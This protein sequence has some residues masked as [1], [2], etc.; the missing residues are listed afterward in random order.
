MKEEPEN[1][2]YKWLASDGTGLF[3]QCWKP[4]A[5]A[6]AVIALVHGL[7]EHSGR[8]AYW[9]GNFCNKNI[10]VLAMDLRGHGHSS[11]KKGHTPSY[12]ML[13][14]DVELLINKAK[15]L[16]P[17]VPVIPYGH[18]MGG[19]LVLNYVLRNTTDESSC[20]ITSPWLKLSFDVP[21]AK[22]LAGKI[23]RGIY[24]SFSQPSGLVADNL[25]RDKN[26]VQN[27]IND[28]LVHQKISI[29]LFSSVYN[30]GLWAIHQA[31]NLN[32]PCLLMHGGQD[33]ITSP[34][35]SEEFNKANPE[36]ITLKIWEG[37]YHELHNEPEK[38]EVFNYIFNWLKPH[39][40]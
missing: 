6:Q 3:A 5:K 8:W 39:I 34:A 33:Q 16:F 26:V 21:R 13:M 27:Y 28:P 38:E 19:N 31:G 14:N 40:S 11:G 2:I 12:G 20:I 30:N 32:I 24:P 17:G 18:S 4:K 35:G 23:V 25:S 1:T 10:A 22:L 36:K 9:A 7:G 37:A 15:E 29:T